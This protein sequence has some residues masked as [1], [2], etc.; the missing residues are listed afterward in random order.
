MQSA[1][2]N[3][4]IKI[5]QETTTKNAVG[6]PV[7]TYSLLKFTWATIK[8]TSGGTEFNEGA[9]PFTDTEFSVRYDSLIDYKCRI[10]FDN[11]YYK[12]LHIELIGRKDGQRLKCIKYDI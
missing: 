2:L 5:E 4:Y 7:E 1:A 9:Q 6:T 10:L 3:R 12:I 8:Y 11:E